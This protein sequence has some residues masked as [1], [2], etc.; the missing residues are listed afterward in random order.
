[1]AEGYLDTNVFVH[2]YAHDQF[3]EECRRLLLALERG[4]VEAVLEPV[5][6]HEL[7]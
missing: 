7:S 4:R 1:M 3:T 6:L 2:A 5:I